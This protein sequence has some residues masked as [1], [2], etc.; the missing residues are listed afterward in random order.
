MSTHVEEVQPVGKGRDPTLPPNHPINAFSPLRKTGIVLS[1]A[2]AGCLANF[3]IAI[4]NV[5]FGCVS[6]RAAS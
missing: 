5:S 3:A 6:H 4:C 1:L 2:Y